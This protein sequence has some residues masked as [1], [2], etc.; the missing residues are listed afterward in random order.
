MDWTLKLRFC[1]WCLTGRRFSFQ[2]LTLQVEGPSTQVIIFNKLHSLQLALHVQ[3]HPMLSWDSRP[4][5]CSVLAVLRKAVT[6]D[7]HWHAN[8]LTFKS[9]YRVFLGAALPGSLIDIGCLFRA[10]RVYF[11]QQS[12]FNGHSDEEVLMCYGCCISDLHVT[13]C[14]L[15]VF[16]LRCSSDSC[17][18]ACAIAC[19]CALVPM[20]LL[21]TQMCI[22]RDP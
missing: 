8:E 11:R 4:Q 3:H 20:C 12:C 13:C 19:V 2:R 9:Y 7:T 6:P 17:I 10:L 5:F 14:T 15:C 21:Q 16:V 18:W 1:R 22:E